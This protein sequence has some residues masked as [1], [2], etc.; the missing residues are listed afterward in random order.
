MPPYA[1]SLHSGNG[2]RRGSKRHNQ[3]HAPSTAAR[4]ASSQAF[5]SR[6]TAPRT[7]QEDTSLAKFQMT[8]SGRF[9]IRVSHGPNESHPRMCEYTSLRQY[10]PLNGKSGNVHS[11]ALKQYPW[12]MK[13]TVYLR[14]VSRRQK[15]ACRPLELHVHLST[16]SIP[17][18]VSRLR[19]RSNNFWREVIEYLPFQW[20]DDVARPKLQARF[21][22][23]RV[24]SQHD[25]QF[26]G[27]LDQP[28]ANIDDFCRRNRQPNALS[29]SRYQE[30]IGEHSQMLRIVSEFDDVKVSVIA[31]QQVC[32][33]AASHSPHVLDRRDCQTE[34]SWPPS[35]RGRPCAYST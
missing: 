21:A 25:V 16:T 17:A 34:S 28:W 2:A 20:A 24:A 8:S 18:N 35:M 4:S 7:S 3:V 22:R 10:T 5:P 14:S 9:S 11:P 32:L 19:T 29:Q 27:V 26:R 30:I 33:C 31:T 13:L 1:A 15:V 6:P 23:D 12:S